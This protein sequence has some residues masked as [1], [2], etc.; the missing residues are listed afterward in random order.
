VKLDA[1]R[2][3]LL[4][5]V[6]SCQLNTMEERVAWVLNHYPKTR[7]SDLTLQIR[8]WQNFQG[9]R[10]EGG[11]ISV[12]DYYRLAKLTSL[13]RARALIQNKLKLFQASE[14]VKKHRKQLEE[15]ERTNALKERPNCHRITV[16]VD[17][18]GKTQDHLIVG[19]MW[20]LNGAET[21]KIYRAVE[22]WKKMHGLEEELHFKSI[23]EAKLPH[24]MELADLISA[25]SATVSFKVVSVPRRGIANI[26]DALLRLTSHLLIRGIEHEHVTGRAPLPR[27]LSVCKD[28]EEVGQDKIFAAELSDKMK[29][30]ALSQFHGD[31]HV[32]ECSAEQ[33]ATNTHLQITD[34]FAS[35]V[36]R[37]LNALG[38]RKH[39]K[40]QFAD[41]FL[42]KLGHTDMA[43]SEAVGDMTAHIAL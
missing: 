42:V 31:L 23:T 15:G 10:F 32:D 4:Q 21:I 27:G 13:A 26:H 30:A 38:E 9:D 6:N 34:L 35:S 33:S 2:A 29:Q 37:K 36:G 12:S 8:F 22:N 39:P 43:N 5:A 40:D 19:S 14:D 25:Q 16:Y 7:D 24:Y 18:S 3:R 28:A 41:Y 17:E 1:R 11:S 20:Y